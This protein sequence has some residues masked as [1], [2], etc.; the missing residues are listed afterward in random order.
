MSDSGN[1]TKIFNI[2][3]VVAILVVAGMAAGGYATLSRVQGDTVRA[4]DDLYKIVYEL[5]S[6]TRDWET[7]ETGYDAEI[8]ARTEA[9]AAENRDTFRRLTDR[10]NDL[11]VRVG[12]L[13][14]GTK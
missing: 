10:L 2:G 14:N 1:G 6:D 8:R 13:A 4:V 11:A 5:K 7:R 9:V 12:A 3:N